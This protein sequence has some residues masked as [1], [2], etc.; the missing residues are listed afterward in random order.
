MWHRDLGGGRL[1]ALR[2]ALQGAASGTAAP[3]LSEDPLAPLCAGERPFLVDSWVLRLAAARDP[4][5]ARPLLERLRGGGF[6]AVIL[7]HGT[8]TPGADAWFSRDLGPA[9]LAEI[10]GHWRPA[11]AAGPYHV[12]L[13]A[14]AGAAPTRPGAP[15]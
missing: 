2:V 1:G 15:E 13:Y 8:D 10:R 14:P 4:E 6:R 11:L 5:I 3:L 7:L 9:A 12:Y